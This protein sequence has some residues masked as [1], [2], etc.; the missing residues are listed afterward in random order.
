MAHDSPTIHRMRTSP[1]SATQGI[2]LEPGVVR[3]DSRPR[4]ACGVTCFEQCVLQKTRARLL[5]RGY[6]EIPL[7]DDFEGQAGQQLA[8]FAQ[9][10]RIAG[11]DDQPLTPR[12]H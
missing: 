6:A 3:D 4:G 9:L 7:R 1:P 2:H 5:G 10:A 8:E 12:V 11:G